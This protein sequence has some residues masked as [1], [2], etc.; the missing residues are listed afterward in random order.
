MASGFFKRIFGKADSF[1]PVKPDQSLF[2][3]GDVH[4]RQDLLER[5]LD[6]AGADDQI[7]CVGDYVDRGD[8]SA[9][10]LKVLQSRPDVLCLKGN[11]EEM[12]LSF[13]KNPGSAGAR[14]L[15]YGGLQTIASYGVA[16]INERSKDEDLEKARDNL[17]EAMGQEIIDWL[18]QLKLWYK[19]GNVAIVH[20]A[21]NPQMP[22]DQQTNSTLLW[23]HPEFDRTARTDGQWVVHGH[24]IVDQAMAEHGRISV[25]TGAYATGRLTAARITD[26]SVDFIAA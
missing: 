18:E 5:L 3:I 6:K 17:V 2:V 15:R 4:G 25:D 13:I 1:P 10:V 9:G 20:A 22:I 11:H 23:G 26:G 12:L 16:G 21:A 8:H 7:I 14:W 24:T 19:S